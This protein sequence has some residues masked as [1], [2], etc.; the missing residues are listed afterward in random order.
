M[1]GERDRG[2]GGPNLGRAATRA[3]G[4]TVRRWSSYGGRFPEVRKEPAKTLAARGHVCLSGPGS[5]STPAVTPSLVPDSTRCGAAAAVALTREPSGPSERQTSRAA[6]ALD[7][8]APNGTTTANTAR[9]QQRNEPSRKG[10]KHDG[11]ASGNDGRSDNGRADDGEPARCVRRFERRQGRRQRVGR[12]HPLEQRQRQG[13]P[14][15]AGHP[16]CRTG[17]RTAR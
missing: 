2:S 13:P 4:A 16:V 14:G 12:R 9:S 15:R 3:F 1:I 11:D 17:T 10:P 7:V 8:D 6:V 5:E